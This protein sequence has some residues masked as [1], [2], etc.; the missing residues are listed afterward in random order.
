MRARTKLALFFPSVVLAV[1]AVLIEI[2]LS[3]TRLTVVMMS[4]LSVAFL[5]EELARYHERMRMMD[6]NKDD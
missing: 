3:S 1:W 6:D 2:D 5:V 4:M